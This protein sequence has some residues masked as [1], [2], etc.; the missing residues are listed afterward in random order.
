M[1]GSEF[2]LITT[3]DWIEAIGANDMV[4]AYGE[5]SFA[6]CITRQEWGSLDEVF[7]ASGYI[8]DGYGLTDARMLSIGTDI[9]TRLRVWL[10]YARLVYAPGTEPGGTP[11][12]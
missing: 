10:R 2:L 11:A 8:P 3:P 5:E 9:N 7:R 12:V 4:F 6:A 1:S